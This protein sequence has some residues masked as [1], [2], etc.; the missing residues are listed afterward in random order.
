MRTQRETRAFESM[1]VHSHFSRLFS[2]KSAVSLIQKSR[3]LFS[4]AGLDSA[5]KSIASGCR[6]VQRVFTWDLTN[7]AF[8]VAF[9]V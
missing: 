6:S 8:T 1:R 9:E 2:Q 5:L 7:E 4:A 3:E